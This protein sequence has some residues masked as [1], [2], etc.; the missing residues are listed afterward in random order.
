M[1][2]VSGGGGGAAG[3]MALDTLRLPEMTRLPSTSGGGVVLDNTVL[4][5]V[6]VG[7]SLSLS[8]LL[9]GPGL[10]SGRGNSPTEASS[11]ITSL[12]EYISNERV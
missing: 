6:D 11:Q 2:E 8:R 12:E 1:A 5:T 7:L 3:A 9:F 4:E 10:G